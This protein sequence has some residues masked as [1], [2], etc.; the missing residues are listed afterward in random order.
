MAKTGQCRPDRFEKCF[1]HCEKK[2]FDHGLVQSG[3]LD[4][5]VDIFRK[6]YVGDTF[7]LFLDGQAGSVVF[8]VV[9]P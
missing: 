2:T 6:F 7:Q 8:V 4:R 3:V 5:M 1:P 9:F